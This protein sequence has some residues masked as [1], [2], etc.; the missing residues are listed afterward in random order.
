MDTGES[1][2]N[3]VTS[4][5][6]IRWWLSW[7]WDST[8]LEFS[9]D[10]VLTLALPC[11]LQNFSRL[12]G[13][14]T[15]AIWKLLDV[16]NRIYFWN[17]VVKFLDD[18]HLLRLPRPAIFTSQPESLDQNL[19]QRSQ[20]VSMFK[21]HGSTG[22]RG[23]QVLPLVGQSASR[24]PHPGVGGISAKRIPCWKPWPNLTWE[25]RSQ[26]RKLPRMT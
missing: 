9:G 23:S 26:R 22:L 7:P 10:L 15:F 16:V 1:R 6:D 2:E 25:W 14:H 8:Y 3:D 11:C 21:T 12:S 20:G 24:I 4:L 5:S 17:R 18:G 13:L 19:V